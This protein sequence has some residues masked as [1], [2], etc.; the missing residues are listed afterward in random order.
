MES[1]FTL[2][3]VRADG[4]QLVL[5]TAFPMLGL[6]HFARTFA[7]SRRLR[8]LMCQFLA[9]ITVL[10]PFDYPVMW[11][12]GFLTSHLT[13]LTCLRV[14]GEVVTNTSLALLAT[15][16]AHLRTLELARCHFDLSLVMPAFTGLTT[17]VLS[18]ATE[19]LVD[20]PLL[21][22]PSLRTLTLE[23]VLYHGTILSGLSLLTEL[24]LSSGVC[25]EMLH[26][27]PLASLRSLTLKGTQTMFRKIHLLTDL[28]SL[29][30][31]NFHLPWRQVRKVLAH[32]AL[33]TRLT[34]LHIQFASD[35]TV[36]SSLLFSPSDLSN[37]IA[38]TSLHLSLWYSEWDQT[39][40]LADCTIPTTLTNLRHLEVSTFH[41]LDMAS[42]N[43]FTQLRGLH[44][45]D[46]TIVFNEMF[47]YWN[48]LSSLEVD[49]AIPPHVLSQLTG[50]TSLSFYVDAST[51]VSSLI[52]LNLLRAFSESDCLF[53]CSRLLALTELTQLELDG[54]NSPSEGFTD[55]TLLSR[56]TNLRNLLLDSY[57]LPSF[58]ELTQLT[59]L[60]LPRFNLQD[61]TPLTCLTSLRYL[62]LD[63][64]TRRVFGLFPRLIHARR[65]DGRTFYRQF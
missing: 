10:T 50:L 60:S 12:A 44:L 18:S 54:P 61:M 14:Y 21:V 43:S 27:S 53:S 38:L 16:L 11:S 2:A 15:R 7:R 49:E 52:R 56:L 3:E 42:L 47:Q 62:T 33:L 46:T 37:L 20:I 36:D 39:D 28:T 64:V 13:G 4:I 26:L 51:E 45:S 55:Q 22:L 63:S 24:S 6:L 8:P 32:C 30:L 25:F 41:T 58:Q 48:Q 35:T 31:S 40:F 19:P 1:E 9:T 34:S 5:Q 59:E 65:N 57:V 23:S 17:L 29:H